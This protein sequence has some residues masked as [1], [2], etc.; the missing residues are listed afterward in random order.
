MGRLECWFP[1]GTWVVHDTFCPLKWIV[2]KN[3]S[4]LISLKH[5]SVFLCCSRKEDLYTMLPWG[6]HCSW[7]K[8]TDLRRGTGNERDFIL[9]FFLFIF[10]NNYSTPKLWRRPWGSIANNDKF[11]SSSN[12]YSGICVQQR[13]MVHSN[14]YMSIPDS[15]NVMKTLTQGSEQGSNYVSMNK[16]QGPWRALS[17]SSCI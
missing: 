14:K 6:Q 11:L 17:A 13:Q 16:V 5:W 9:S 2:T 12:L 1:C 4:V 10:F 8:T 7:F 15:D 3:M